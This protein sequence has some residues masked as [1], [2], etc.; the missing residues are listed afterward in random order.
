M[1]LPKELTHAV[2]EAVSLLGK[3]IAREM[4]Q[5]GFELVEKIRREV[6]KSAEEK[7]LS[8]KYLQ[9]EKLYEAMAALDE[10]TRFQVAHAFALMLELI[11]RCESAYRTF[12]LGQTAIELKPQKVSKIIYVLTAH[13]TEARSV[14]V[15]ELFRRIQKSILEALKEDSFSSVEAEL[16]HLLSLAWRLSMSKRMA[17]TVAD[18]AETIF[19]LLLTQANLELMAK[20]ERKGMNIFIRTWVGGDKDGHPGV[21]E[22]VMLKSLSLSRRKILDIWLESLLKTRADLQLLLEGAEEPAG[23]GRAVAELERLQSRLREMETVEP[24]DGDRVL[25]VH[26]QLEELSAVYKKM[27]GSASP[28]LGYLGSLT[29]LFPGLVVPLELREDSG[30]VREALQNP[31]RLAIEKMLA[32]LKDVTAGGSI[33]HYA[34]GFILSMTESAGDIL[35][36]LELV[37]RATGSCRLPVVPLFET[38]KALEDSVEILGD[39]LKDEK[40][41]CLLHEEWDRKFEVMLGYSDSAK[42]SGSLPSRYMIRLSLH[43]IEVLLQGHGFIPIFFHGSGGSVERGGGSIEEQTAWWPKSALT[44]FKATIQGEMI[45]R[46]FASPEI[47]HGQLLKIAHQSEKVSTARLTAEQKRDLKKFVDGVK[48]HYQAAIAREDFLQVVE[49]AT[50]YS[51]LEHMKIGSRPSKRSQGISMK[52][53]RAIPWVLCWTQTRVLFPAWWGVGA[54]W[55]KLS[56][57]E[58]KSLRKTYEADPLF[59]SY[60]KLLGFTLA[61]IELAVWRLYLEKSDLSQ[62]GKTR[63]LEE[64][65]QEYKNSA[66]C[67][68]AVTGEK[69]LIWYRPWLEESIRLRAPLIHPLNILQVIAFERKDIPLLQETIT[70]IASG[71]LTTG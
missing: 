66:A 64:F 47:L 52:S 11:N 55:S 28:H 53:L 44:N 2:N 67:L 17:P 40:R 1:R 36:G 42:Q 58:K 71:M 49:K 26:R 33:I 3:T 35:A 4:S 56:S 22:K 41:T 12:R 8:K 50:P 51:Y 13:P 20:Y 14:Q 68:R 25:S 61:K 23:Y 60:M 39:F 63:V 54:S 34:R 19:S 48:V 37:K 38:E 32:A 7:D 57:A 10:K 70:G 62:E 31:G 15:L 43:H 65:H 29:R 30:L 24:G 45:Q 9:I 6:K 59:R 16:A 5:D 46:S 27:V 18:E 69:S 21:D